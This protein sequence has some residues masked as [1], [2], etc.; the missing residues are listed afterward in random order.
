[1]PHV[2]CHANRGVPVVSTRTITVWESLHVTMG[3]KPRLSEQA[4]DIATRHATSA[5]VLYQAFIGERN[6]IAPPNGSR[7]SCGR[8]ARRR[9]G[10][11]RQSVPARAQHSVSF[12]AIGAR[13]LQALVRRRT[14]L[15]ARSGSALWLV[16]DRTDKEVARA[17]LSTTHAQQRGNLGPMAN[18]VSHSLHNQLSRRHRTSVRSDLYLLRNVPPLCREGT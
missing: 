16:E 17:R 14:R 18:F 10:V 15:V 6:I 8:P 4:N 11:G 12:R 7:L 2:G 13:Q 5:I 3:S 9:K 1:M